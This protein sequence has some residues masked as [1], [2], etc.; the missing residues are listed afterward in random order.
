MPE[1]MTLAMSVWAAT[2]RPRQ[3][4]LRVR[5]KAVQQRGEGSPRLARLGR[6]CCILALFV[7]SQQMHRMLPEF[8]HIGQSLV[9]IPPVEKRF[10]T[11]EML[12]IEQI[13]RHVVH[14]NARRTIIVSGGEQGF[15]HRIAFAGSDNNVLAARTALSGGMFAVTAIGK[16]LQLFDQPN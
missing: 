6:Q 4:M 5:G 7:T 14:Y 2:G 16:E 10:V 1:R 15:D 11:V 8:G 13:I 12:K 9:R 3:C